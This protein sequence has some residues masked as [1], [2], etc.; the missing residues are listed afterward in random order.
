M[1]TADAQQLEPG[2]RITVYELDA[3]SFGADKLFFHAHLQSGVI[4][5]QGQEYGPWPIESSGFERTSDQP[6]NPR[7][8][9]SNIDGRITAMCLLFDDL[10]GA[11]I[12]RRQ[13]L[14]KYLDATNFEEGNPSADPAR[15]FPDDVWFIERKIGEDKQMVEVELT[16][17]IDL[18]G[19]QLPG[20]QI[21]AGM[22]GGLVRGGYRGA[23]CGYNGPAVADSDD[24]PTDDPAR[25]Q[26]GGRV[27][28]CK[29]RFG[30]DKPLPY[31]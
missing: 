17:A 9:V 16:T 24:V 25:D 12:I 14:A 2:G 11:R 20:R 10:V 27:R 5:W 3:S 15:H 31:G 1:I 21:I 29:L 28:S 23:Y 6:P 7:L 26:C 18:N 22:C 30:Q 4:W 19:Q 13:T 8:R